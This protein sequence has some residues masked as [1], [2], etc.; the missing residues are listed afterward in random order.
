[1]VASKK[2]QTTKRT[3]ASKA[4]KSAPKKGAVG[5]KT[6]KKAVARPLTWRFYAVTIGIFVIAIGSV[7]VLALLIT[8]V[9][10]SKN[11]LVAGERL[12]R[13]TNIY[14]SL[15]LSDSYTVTGTHVFGEKRTYD[16]DKNHTQSST[17]TYTYGDTV[18]NTVT[19]LDTKIKAA[20]F[21]FVDQTSPESAFTRYN[22]QS[23]KGEYLSLTVSSKPRDDAF[24]NASTM[25]QDPTAA[26]AN[27]DANAGPSNIVIKVNLDDNNE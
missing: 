6:A 15:E 18:A 5:K 13:I 17:V 10:T 1:M 7:M 25:K 8:N 14:N 3:A 2:S 12:A 26:V 24:R 27:M 4:V 16:Y 22:Y 20:G 23:A 21:S 9:A 11:E 19:A